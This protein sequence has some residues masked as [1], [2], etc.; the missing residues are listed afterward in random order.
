[1]GP[2]LP[3]FG[4]RILY[5]SAIHRNVYVAF[6]MNGA[7]WNLP[8]S[9]SANLIALKN[10]CSD[11]ILDTFIEDVISWTQSPT[12]VFTVSSAWNTIRPRRPMV[13][14]HAVVWFSHA[15]KIHSFITWLV[16][17][18]RLSTE[19]KLFKWGLINTIS[20]VYCWASVEESWYHP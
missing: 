11:Y 17:Q 13:H 18:D 3:L 19:D 1:M 5:D 6:I 4:E 10:S 14:W 15:I 12:G 2:L 8:V 20:C 16:L 9:V 7:R